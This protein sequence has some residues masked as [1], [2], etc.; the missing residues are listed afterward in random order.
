MAG[1]CDDIF[2]FAE[3]ELPL[4]L[5]EEQVVFGRESQN[6]HRSCMGNLSRGGVDHHLPVA[7]LAG[8]DEQYSSRDPLERDSPREQGENGRMQQSGND[9]KVL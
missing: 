2:P 7:R 6:M 1:S 3:R 9:G 4:A 8:D 5:R